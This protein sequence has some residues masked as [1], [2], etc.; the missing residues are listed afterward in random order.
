[1]EEDRIKSALEIAMEKAANMPGL[2]SEELNEQREREYKPRGIA[3]ANKYLETPLKNSD[4]EVEL[5]RY[6]GKEGEIVRKAFLSTLCQSIGFEDPEKGRRAIDGIQKL[7]TAVPLHEMKEE[8]EKI[9]EEFHQQRQQRYRVLEESEREKLQGLG[10][11][12]SAVKPNL[13]DKE[14]WQQEVKELQSVYDS[15]ISKLREKLLN[16]IESQS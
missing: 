2:S 15:R 6:Q 8:V 14:N 16:Y 7:E 9:S 11:S 12:G 3:I 1:M 10:I 13:E 4:L 5:H